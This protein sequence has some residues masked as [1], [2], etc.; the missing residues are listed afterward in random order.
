L[1]IADNVADFFAMLLVGMSVSLF[2]D[3]QRAVRKAVRKNGGKNHTLSVMLQD[4]LFSACSLLL[5]LLVVYRI[6]DGIV[7]SYIVLGFIA[8]AAL[9]FWVI[10]RVVGRVIFS[11]FYAILF[12]FKKICTLPMIFKKKSVK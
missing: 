12:I 5:V 6:N 4:L 1:P 2:F 7:R 8:G 3:F 11:V 9:Y 10:S